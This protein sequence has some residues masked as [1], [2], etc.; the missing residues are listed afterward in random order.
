MN[1][2]DKPNLTTTKSYTLR[3]TVLD[4]TLPSCMN[5]FGILNKA[6]IEQCFP[7]CILKESLDWQPR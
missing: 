2:Y 6:S 4:A 3:K 7:L 5:A 1:N